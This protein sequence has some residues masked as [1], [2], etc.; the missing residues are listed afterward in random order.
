[1]VYK[2]LQVINCILLFFLLGPDTPIEAKSFVSW[3]ANEPVKL[4]T[5]NTGT[6]SQT[7]IS[8]VTAFRQTV[9]RY[10]DHPALGKSVI[11]LLYIQLFY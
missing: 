8:I 11:L 6:L 2:E 5:S 7:P 4:R 10:P 3:T 1:M 9:A